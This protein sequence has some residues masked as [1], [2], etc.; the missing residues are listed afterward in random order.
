MKEVRD[1][2]LLFFKHLSLD[3][4]STMFPETLVP[5]DPSVLLQFF[6]AVGV[7]LVA[8]LPLG[9]I[10]I[11]TI[12]RAMS[13]GFRR[14][15]LPTLGAMTGNTIFGV[16]AALGSGY[17][18]TSIIGSRIWLRF[19]ASVVLV[20]IGT[21]LLND[22]KEDRP[23]TRESFGLLQLAFLKFT[24]VL[25][26]PLTL[27]FYIAAFAALGLESPGVFAGQSFVLGGGILFGTITWFLFICAAAS[28]FQHKASDLLL[29]RI[30]KGVG[31]LLI[32]L[33]LV[34]VISGIMGL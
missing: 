34:S 12:Q 20:F 26:N 18:S 23:D 27:G 17:L 19:V 2:F 1:A 11:L 10:S 21:R 25:T 32:I 30:R 16:L 13:L 22:R 8:K 4:I 9:S 31:V 33:G 24:L 14:A 5:A 3:T 7:A 29:N 6:L 15:F 28:R